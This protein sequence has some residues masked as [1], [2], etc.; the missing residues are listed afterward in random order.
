MD[1]AVAAA[2]E[3]DAEA[4]PGSATLPRPTTLGI[5]P[6]IAAE[7]ARIRNGL[8]R[9]I[10]GA[11]PEPSPQSWSAPEPPPIAS[12]LPPN[13]ADRE[14]ASYA[15]GSADE[16]P[17]PVEAA[18]EVAHEAIADAA[19]ETI[20][21]AAPVEEP[22]AAAPETAL[23]SAPVA[24]P[25]SAPIAVEAPP[26]Q[27]EVKQ[28]METRTLSDAPLTPRPAPQPAVTWSPPQTSRSLGGPRMGA[29]GVVLIAGIAAVGGWLVTQNGDWGQATASL[30][31]MVQSVGLP[32][33]F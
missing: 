32:W 16:L 22:E 5:A 21:E 25:L 17:P 29:S 19:P 26:P 24:E 2:S 33:P 9:S 3:A 27:A 13:P 4:H 12:A 7:A 14:Y 11:P 15:A 28:V 23:E 31:H 18:P 10:S 6:D 30:H 8:Q 20:R 1:D